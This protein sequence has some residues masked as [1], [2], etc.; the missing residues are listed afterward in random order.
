[1]KLGIDCLISNA[2][3]QKQ[4][5]NKKVGVVANPASITSQLEH[6]L[7]AIS[8]IPSITISAAFGPQHGMRGDKQDNMIES[9]NYKDSKHNIPV[10]SLYGDVRRPTTDMM[11]TFD[12][13]LFDIQ[14]LGCRIYTYITTLL[15]L[16]EACAEHQKPLWVLDRPNPAGRVIEG[17]LLIDGW[18]SF[19]G[20][21]QIPMRH[22]LTVGELALWFAK[23]HNLDID[24]HIVKMQ[25][26]K[27]NQSPG[28]GWP[29]GD[30]PWV[31]PSPNAAS[32]NM[33]R[34]YSGSVLI[35]GTELSEGRGTTIPLEIIGAPDIEIDLVLK[36]M[37]SL[38]PQW[39]RGAYIR[40]IY[41]EPTSHK[42]AHTLCQGFQVHTDTS[43]YQPLDFRPFRLVLLFL[44]AIRL[45]YPE[46]QL[47]RK[48]DYEYETDRLA[49][50]IINGG[51]L[52]RAWVDDN[53][54][55][56]GDMQTLL[57]KDEQYWANAIDEFL[58]YQ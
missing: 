42:H 30:L 2:K 8:Q 34:F 16:M 3:Y 10:F 51:T 6:S 55:S 54:S 22:G 49:F 40:P 5:V 27:P 13:L 47:W 33:A 21:G 7:D 23:H 52:I 36:K 37:S 44:K 38:A 20:A 58:L 45:L 24:L 12:L 48:F 4:L 9:G 50:D 26:Y 29:Q 35:E 18:Q 43:Q 1:M 41:F 39:M 46:Y 14:D 15:Y 32:L 31:N 53:A 11:S 28:Y 57:A 19:V 25:D 17:N 56:I